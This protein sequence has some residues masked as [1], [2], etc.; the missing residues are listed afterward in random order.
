M[1]QACSQNS[2]RTRRYRP[3]VKIL[4]RYRP[5]V[6]ILFRYRPVMKILFILAGL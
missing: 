5:V 1:E 2:I 3:V 6:K 4:F